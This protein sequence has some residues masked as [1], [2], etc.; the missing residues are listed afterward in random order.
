MKKLVF[1][2]ILAYFLVA[3]AC[4]KQNIDTEPID[5]HNDTG[6]LFVKSE[7]VR[8]SDT[9]VTFQRQYSYNTDSKLKS[10]SSIQRDKAPNG[11]V[12]SS[13]WITTFY[14]DN[15][16]RIERIGSD[17]DTDPIKTH[18]NYPNT[19]ITLPD[20]L[21]VS[22]K[23]PIGELV[24]DSIL[25]TYNGKSQLEKAIHFL[26]NP[27]G[28][29][30]KSYFELFS[31]DTRGNVTKKE[32]YVVSLVNGTDELS[33]IFEWEYDTK[34]NPYFLNE[35]AYF[36]NTGVFSS[37]W[38]SPNNLIREKATYVGSSQAELNH[39]Y[40]YNSK[41]YPVSVNTVGDTER[42]LKFYYQ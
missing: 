6:N 14:R 17:P 7:S 37:Y 34:I 15:Y 16:G 39:V 30:S 41:S 4:Q 12:T 24:M 19:N 35:I 31:Y 8:L 11:V 3:L 29:L 13:A 40:N 23:T 1:I 26:R 2:S 9:F 36:F 32:Q 27:R 42:V 10:I 21:L 33:A 18:F 5:N 20:Y 38:A 28:Q 22:T 25:L